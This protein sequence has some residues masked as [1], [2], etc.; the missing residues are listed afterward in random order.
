MSAGTD[1]SGLWSAYLTTVLDITLPGGDVRRLE[2]AEPTG[3]QDWPWSGDQA[4]IMTACNPR[5]EP[6]SE[7]VNAQ[8]HAELGEQLKREHHEAFPNT[9]FDPANSAWHEPGYTILG[10]TE[11]DVRALAVQW[12]QNAVY[13]WFPDR[14]ELVGA[15]MQGRTVGQW[16]WVS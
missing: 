16:R 7:S 4:W 8:R 5:S 11:A 1:P 10:I 13:G 15:L 6:L 2:Q 12:G 9:G 3:P 14:W